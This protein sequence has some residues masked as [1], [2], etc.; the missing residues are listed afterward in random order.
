MEYDKNNYYE[1]PDDENNERYPRKKRGW[2]FTVMLISLVLLLT[3]AL[4]A[5]VI[6]S[7]NRLQNLPSPSPVTTIEPVSEK[8]EEPQKTSEQQ[9]ERTPLPSTRPAVVFDGELPPIYD[10]VNPIPDIVDGV[11]EGVVGIS[12]YGEQKTFGQKSFDSLQGTGTGFVISSEGYLVTNAHV[13]DGAKKVEVVFYD[14]T[15][16]EAEILGSDKTLDI[17]I[18]KVD[19]TGLHPLKLGTSGTLRVGQFV[20]AIGDATG[21]EL[22]GTTTFGLVSATS[23]NVNIDGRSN[24]YI[25]TDAAVNPGNSGGPMLNMKGEVIGITSAKTLTAGYDDFGNPITAEGIG[26]AIPIDNAIDTINQLITVGHMDRPGVGVTVI[27]VTEQLSEQLQIPM[28]VLIYTITKDG[29]AHKAGLKIDDVITSIDGQI[30][31]TQEELVPFIRSK[32]VGGKIEIGLTR[33]GKQMTIQLT[34]GDLNLL[35]DELVEGESII[36]TFEEN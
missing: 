14:G 35:G 15:E 24:T 4:I 10:T 36:D 19:R 22:A 12:N 27:T 17:A 3:G 34:I 30:I 20:I 5:N 9:P 32:G 33:D 29:P 31:T 8:T 26:F 21:R 28:G 18:L 11:K 1:Q 25:Q 16:M 7:S 6:V 2:V 23:R 13:I